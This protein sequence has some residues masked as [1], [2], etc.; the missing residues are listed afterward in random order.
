MGP[1][2]RVGGPVVIVPYLT[3]RP[4]LANTALSEEEFDRRS[5]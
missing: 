5:Y 1:R 4:M 3:R 2:L